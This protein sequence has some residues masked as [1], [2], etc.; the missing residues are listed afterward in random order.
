[1]MLFSAKES[2]KG[3]ATPKGRKKC[4]RKMGRTSV[5]VNKDLPDTQRQ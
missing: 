2:R 1:M 4:H 5:L 3:Y